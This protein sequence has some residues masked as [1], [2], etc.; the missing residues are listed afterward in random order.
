M[1]ADKLVEVQL[2][3]GPARR[4]LLHIEIQSQREASLARRIIDYNYRIFKEY[5]LLVISLVVLADE[6]PSWRPHAFHNV[7]PGAVMGISF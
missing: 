4:V 7:L 6:V 1:V 5:G 2:L 3:A